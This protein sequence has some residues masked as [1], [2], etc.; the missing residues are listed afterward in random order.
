MNQFLAKFKHW[1][2]SDWVPPTPKTRGAAA[3]RSVIALLSPPSG[4]GVDE[5]ECF[6]NANNAAKMSFDATE[7]HSV[8]NL[9]HHKNK[10]HLQLQMFDHLVQH[11]CKF[12]KRKENQSWHLF[13]FL[14]R[15]AS[16]KEYLNGCKKII[17][18]KDNIF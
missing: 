4:E 5:N 17:F 13:S 15:L 14:R 3:E 10:V 7:I 6:T 16:R 18:H 12:C 11:L 1:I 2:E 9:I 8:L